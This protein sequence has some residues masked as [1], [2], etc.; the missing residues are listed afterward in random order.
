MNIN[1]T[2]AAYRVL[3]SVGFFSDDD[4][5]YQEGDEIY[6]DGV[7]NEELEPLNELAKQRLEAY[8]TVLDQKAREVAE[9]TGRPFVG[10][11]RNLDGALTLA[12][13]VQ[14]ANMQ[15]MGSKDKV[16]STTRIEKETPE[17]GTQNPK[18]RGRP[19]KTSL[20]A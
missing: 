15:I 13:E 19:S 11:P 2:Q 4:H 6:F 5:L 18:R 16:T 8:L 3:S 7:P 9:K 10:R 14:R 1:N 12:T 17:V 20:A